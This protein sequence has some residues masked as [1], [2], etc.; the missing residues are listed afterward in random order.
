MFT[1]LLLASKKN[2]MI[3]K[4]YLLS[5][6]SF[7]FFAFIAADF[8]CSSYLINHQSF[9]TRKQKK[10]RFVIIAFTVFFPFF[11][12]HFRCPCCTWQ[13]NSKKFCFY[14]YSCCFGYMHSSVWRIVHSTPFCKYT[15]VFPFIT[16]ITRMRRKTFAFT[17]YARFSLCAMNEYLN[18]HLICANVHKKQ[19]H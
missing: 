11:F 2:E 19:F 15:W 8:Y 17:L 3:C 10:K 4:L 12:V 13:L 9:Y 14:C 6:T 1:C 5:F 7:F 18:E 16:V